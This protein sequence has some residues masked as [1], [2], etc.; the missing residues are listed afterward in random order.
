MTWAIGEVPPSVWWAAGALAVAVALAAWIVLV[1]SRSLPMSRRRYGVTAEPSALTRAPDASTGAI[2]RLL[3]SR[4]PLESLTQQLDLAGIRR[5]VPEFVVLV[6]AVALL[7]A[8]VGV[9]L[10]GPLIAIKLAGMAIAGAIVFVSFRANSAALTSPTNWMTSCN[11]SA[12]TCGPATRSSRGWTRWP[13]SW[14]SQ[15]GGAGRQPGAGGA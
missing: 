12:A 6:G 14:R 1:P 5:S 10:G 15:R 13:E 4:G 8:A 11:C 7:G 9:L 3:R 2:D